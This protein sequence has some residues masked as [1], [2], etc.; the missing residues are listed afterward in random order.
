MIFLLTMIWSIED[1]EKFLSLA[2]FFA[3]KRTLVCVSGIDSTKM[4]LS[5]NVSVLTY[6]VL[7]LA[8]L[9]NRLRLQRLMDDAAEL[10][11]RVMTRLQQ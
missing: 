6:T 3:G 1:K 7:Y 11:T 9:A 8:W 4:V 5:L 2:S 10:K